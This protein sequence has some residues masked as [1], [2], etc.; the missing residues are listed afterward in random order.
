M[1]I[2]NRYIIITAIKHILI[3][4]AV[5]VIIYIVF[6]F[7]DEVS[8]VGIE[9]Y[10][11]DKAFI[12][13]I[14]S[15]PIAMYD[16][17]PLVV[18]VGVILGLSKFSES[19]EL[20]AIRASGLSIHYL[21]LQ[22]LKAGSLFIFVYLI[23]N[24]LFVFKLYNFANEY[25]F[26]AL[27]HNHNNNNELWGHNKNK[28]FYMQFNS[29]DSLKYIKLINV[30]DNKLQSIISSSNVYYKNNKLSVLNATKTILYDNSKIV[31]KIF[32]TK[33]DLLPKNNYIFANKEPE[34]IN[35][36][37]LLQYVN[38]NNAQAK[39]KFVLYT[40]VMMPVLLIAMV[41]LGLVFVFGALRHLNLGKRIF[42]GIVFS[43]VFNLIVRLISE[44]AITFGYNIFLSVFLPVLIL[45]ML[46]LLALRYR[47][48]VF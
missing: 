7:L 46:S 26:K 42:I 11:F 34:Y 2:L 15:L 35:S 41:I 44:I 40:R 1:S 45:F 21:V 25:K 18:L 4:L 14:L 17:L 36:Y 33:L 9:S 10:S 29:D 6:A 31:N 24:E 28:F 22:L 30:N 12:F 16:F 37:N 20:M 5:L 43:L 32:N 39:Y 3:V 48:S 23:L 27:K 47:L 13:V 8:S 38:N 19:K